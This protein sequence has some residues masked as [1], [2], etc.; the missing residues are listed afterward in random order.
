MK[1]FES[2]TTSRRDAENAEN[3]IL[4]SAL[5]ASLREAYSLSMIT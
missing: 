1:H 5:F 4:F 2:I 3:S